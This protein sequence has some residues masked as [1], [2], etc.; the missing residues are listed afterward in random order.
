MTVDLLE[1]M[2]AFPT[3]DL[4]IVG[5]KLGKDSQAEALNYMH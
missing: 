4:N 5:R 2:R 3:L 1:G